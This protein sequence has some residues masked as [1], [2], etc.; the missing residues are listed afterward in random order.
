MIERGWWGLKQHNN[1]R[2]RMD[3]ILLE[4]RISLEDDADIIAKCED[5]VQALCYRVAFATG[6]GWRETKRLVAVELGWKYVPSVVEADDQGS[7]TVLVL[8]DRTAALEKQ[9]ATW[10]AAVS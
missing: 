5:K 7:G 1:N 3:Y 4:H 9:I 10:I 2:S 6:T 8:V